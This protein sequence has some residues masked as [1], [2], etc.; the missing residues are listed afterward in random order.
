V[1]YGARRPQEIRQTTPWQAAPRRRQVFGQERR[2]LV[3]AKAR[4]RRAQTE[5]RQVHQE[6]Y[7]DDRTGRS[8]CRANALRVGRGPRQRSPRDG[9]PCAKATM[10]RERNENENSLQ[11]TK[12][13]NPV[14]EPEHPRE[15]RDST[16]GNGIDREVRHQEDRQRQRSGPRKQPLKGQ[17]NGAGGGLGHW[18]W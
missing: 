8:Q 14:D 5:L 15:R 11:E 10:Q 13:G 1:K 4:T 12:R 18:A 3:A 9:E 2:D 17:R 16:D 6:K 7:Q